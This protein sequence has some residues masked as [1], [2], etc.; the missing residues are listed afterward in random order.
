MQEDKHASVE[1]L[2]VH[3]GTTEHEFR[4]VVPPIYQTSTFAFENAD[5]GAALFAGEETGF[6]YTR[7]GN[8][9]VQALEDSVAALEG[10]EKALACS[11]GMAAINTTLAGLLQTGD[12]VVCS[13]AVYGPTCTLI[14]SHLRR[15]GIE[16]TLVNTADLGAVRKAMRANTRVV[17]VETPGNPT[18]VASDIEAVSALAHRQGAIVVVDNTFLSPVL[19]QPLRF[20]ADVVCTA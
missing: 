3:G 10:G 1:T 17:Y 7:M 2:A 6:I 9:T 12:H 20:G 18:L 11:S 8:P 14:E 5:Q 4:P 15:F 19:Q 16:A 13:D